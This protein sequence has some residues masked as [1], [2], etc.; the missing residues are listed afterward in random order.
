MS[1]STAN[2]L[3]SARHE[4]ASVGRARIG[5]VVANTGRDLLVMI[6]TGATART[7]LRLGDVMVLIGEGQ[8]TVGVVS[9]MN[10]PAPGLESDGDDL[11]IAQV[12]LMGTIT[13]AD[14][15]LGFTRS[16]PKPPALGDIAYRASPAD[17]RRLYRNGDEKSYPIGIVLGQ[18]DVAATIDGEGLVSGGFT[19][20]G[21]PG[22]GKSSTAV[23][24]VRALLR[25]RH[26]IRTVLLDPNNEY[27]RCFGKAAK[28]VAPRPGTFPHWILSFREFVWVLSCNGGALSADECSILEEAIPAARLRFVQRNRLPT[29]AATSMDAVSVDGPIP[30]RIADLIAHIDKHIASDEYRG[31][32]AYQRLRTR[33]MS[34]VGDPRLSVLFGSVAATDTLEGLLKQIFCLEPDSPPTTVIQLGRLT[35]GLDRLVVSLICRM[36]AALAEWSMGRFRTLVLIDDAGRYAP[37]T[38]HDRVTELSLEAIRHLGNR[39]RKLGTTLG[40]IANQP[41]EVHSATLNQTASFFI[42]RLPSQADVEAVEERLPESAAAFLGGLSN[43]GDGEVV[44]I[45][46]GLPMAGR[47]AIAK[48]PETAIPRENMGPDSQAGEEELDAVAALVHRWRYCGIDEWAGPVMPPPAAPK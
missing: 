9:G 27:G 45:G 7:A 28:C 39:P 21:A 34:A 47:I 35:A 29:D 4:G 10:M 6:E 20:M 33:I 12:E 40:I 26:P 22:S 42:H 11:W 48:L 36:S 18:D 41:R 30:Y 13:I 44:G 17:L 1:S 24:L 38:P 25:N 43:L 32:A 37:P 23:S 31:R 5:R 2:A 46:R 19:V 14:E 8:T 16:I 3:R 15:T